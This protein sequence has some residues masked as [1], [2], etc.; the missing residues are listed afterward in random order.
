MALGEVYDHLL[1]D[2]TALD[3]SLKNAF[4]LVHLARLVVHPATVPP[5]ADR[6]AEG[7]CGGGEQSPE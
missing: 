3:P 1:L 4:T 6:A 5:C 7:A 2:V